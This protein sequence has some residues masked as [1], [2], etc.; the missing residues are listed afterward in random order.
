MGYYKLLPTAQI[1]YDQTGASV[2]DMLTF[3]K[4]NYTYDDSIVLKRLLECESKEYELLE[5]KE[6][7]LIANLMSAGYCYYYKGLAYNDIHRDKKAVEVR[8]LMEEIPHFTEI[9]FE[10]SDAAEPVAGIGGLENHR[11]CYACKAW[12]HRNGIRKKYDFENAVSRIAKL[13]VDKLVLTGDNPLA[14]TERLKELVT[15]IRKYMEPIPVEVIT[16][17]MRQEPEILSF[18]K[19]YNVSV[20][21][22]DGSASLEDNSYE[23]RINRSNPEYWSN[24][25]FHHCLKNKLAI[26]T[27][28]FV[29]PCPM[30]DDDLLDLEK[31][32]ID[33]LFQEQTLDKYWRLTKR[34]IEG[35]AKCRNR[36]FC[37]D[38]ALTELAVKSGI[39]KHEA[40]CEGKPEN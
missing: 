8:G 13:W 22:Y 30:I 5:E 19:E 2:V 28:G 26:T 40:F 14:R 10:V 36:Y 9:F 20:R 32:P 35:C 39:L 16:P 27:D 31:D 29:R 18:L 7:E 3:E 17:A 23:N 33:R 4:T 24:Q 37:K 1:I 6:K 34:E 21:L 11:G 15:C 38:C 25:T 12:P